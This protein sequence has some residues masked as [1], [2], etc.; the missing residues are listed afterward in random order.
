MK[1]N[2]SILTNRRAFIAQAGL[3]SA[4]LMVIP[5]ILTAKPIGHH[6]VG[7]QL[8]TLGDLLPNHVSEVMSKVAQAGFKEVEPFDYSKKNG[9]WGKDAKAFN[10]L[11]NANGLK[12]RSGHFDFDNFFK[13][14]NTD[15]LYSAIDAAN[16]VGMEY[17]VV[18][19]MHDSLKTVADFKAIVGK[20]NTAATILKKEGMTLGYHNHNYEWDRVDGTTFYDTILNETDPTAVK[21]EMDLYYVVRAGQ[22][23]V[24]IMKAHPGRFFAFHIKDMDK[25]NPL[26]N[27]EIGKGSI[28]FKRIMDNAALGGVKHFYVEQENFTNIDPYVSITQSC[29]YVKDVLNV[30]YMS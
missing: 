5:N 11:L 2:I 15:E 21:M 26:L 29:A 18:P 27:T 30:T 23:P 28:D 9:F 25:T 13:T 22:D 3:L 10:E 14:G 24:S 1:P 19:H 17:I 8:R 4:G 16:I 7:L 12:A 6:G 20:L